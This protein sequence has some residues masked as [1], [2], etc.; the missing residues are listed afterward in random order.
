MY[1]YTYIGLYMYIYVYVY[2]TMHVG[3]LSIM[4]SSRLRERRPGRQRPEP[5]GCNDVLWPSLKHSQTSPSAGFLRVA[6]D[7]MHPPGGP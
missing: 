5:F 3:S 2:R 7:D 4:A 6:D 1:M